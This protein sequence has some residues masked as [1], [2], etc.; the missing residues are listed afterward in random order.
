MAG[1]RE[2]KDARTVKAI[3][4][5]GDSVMNMRRRRRSRTCFMK[6]AFMNLNYENL[7][8]RWR[9]SALPVLHGVDAKPTIAALDAKNFCNSMH[10]GC[11]YATGEASFEAQA[12][13]E[14]R[15]GVGSR[16]I[17]LFISGGCIRSGRADTGRAAGAE[18]CTKSR[19]HAW[20]RGNL[21][22]Q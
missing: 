6:K 1:W 15:P 22:R 4:D 21:R 3:E 18:R 10:G 16:R 11:N 14:S 20:G 5:H 2:C 19:N 7:I 9:L 17:D 13:N 12:W 8:C